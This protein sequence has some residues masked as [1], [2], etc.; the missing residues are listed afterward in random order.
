M[1]TVDLPKKLEAL[2][3]ELALKTHRSESDYVRLAVEQFLE[4][5][6]DYL[7]A[8]QRLQEMEDENDEGISFEEILRRNKLDD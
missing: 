2:L 7:L 6:I 1:L 4:N 3:S 8:S 5:K